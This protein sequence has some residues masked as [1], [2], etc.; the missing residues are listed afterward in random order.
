[1]A[2]IP[3]KALA[4][5]TALA[6]YDLTNP[7]EAEAITFFKNGPA[8]RFTYIQTKTPMKIYDWALQNADMKNLLRLASVAGGSAVP[9][10]TMA[11]SGQEKRL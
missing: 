2:Q 6:A 3:K 4:L 5:I 7:Y 10:S 11:N 9:L 1:M 8:P